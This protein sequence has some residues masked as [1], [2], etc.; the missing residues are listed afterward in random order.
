MTCLKCEGLP[1]YVSTIP[2]LP[3]ERVSD[4]PPFTHLG[5]DFAG[6]LYIR[7]HNSSN[8]RKV[9][10]CLFM[11]AST[12]AIHLELTDMLSA[13]S[14]LLAFRRF[15]ARQ[16][17]PSTMWSDNA[18]TFKVAS[19]EIQKIVCSLEVANYLTTNRVTWK[20]IVERAPRWG[21]F[22]E[23]MVHSVKRC[24]RKCIGRSSL[25]H[26]EL[27]TLLIEVESV[28]N[29]RPLTYVFDDSEGVS[30]MLSPSHLIYGCKIA[31][32]PNIGHY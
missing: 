8:E 27:N 23:H 22:W 29:S 31:N 3:V 20:F 19:K 21:G 14:F 9:Y 11:C 26:D 7:R 30:Y 12:R 16:G 15:V 18:K 17:L 1:Y 10:I 4:D 6:A 2:D 28:L 32:I 24:L 25:N 5:I 13:D